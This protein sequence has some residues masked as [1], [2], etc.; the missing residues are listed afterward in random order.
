MGLT[1]SAAA[2]DTPQPP[3]ALYSLVIIGIC[4]IVWFGV[5]GCNILKSRKPDSHLPK[6]AMEE[7]SETDR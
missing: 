4:L 3:T 7:I 6:D 1:P 5:V 2:A